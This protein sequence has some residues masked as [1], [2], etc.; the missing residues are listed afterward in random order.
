MAIELNQEILDKKKLHKI[1]LKKND[2][3]KLFILWRWLKMKDQ[4][5]IAKKNLIQD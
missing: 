4:F 1:K 2:K 3:L 5:I